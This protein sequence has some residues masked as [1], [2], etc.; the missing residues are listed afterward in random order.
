MLSRNELKSAINIIKTYTN[1]FQTVSWKFYKTKGDAQ[2]MKN[3][4]S[5]KF[6]FITISELCYSFVAPISIDFRLLNN[7]ILASVLCSFV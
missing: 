1:H 7:F 2:N 3:K 6:S 4:F 5:K